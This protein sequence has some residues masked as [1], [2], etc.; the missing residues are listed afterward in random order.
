MRLKKA[1]TMAEAILVMTILGIIATIMISTLKPSQ[2]K[3]QAFQVLSKSIYAEIDSAM[4]QILTN[5]TR[6]NTLEE[7]YQ[8]DANYAPTTTIFKM[9]AGS[10][11]GEFVKILKKYMATAR[12]TVPAICR[13]TSLEGG[14]GNAYDANM[15]LKNGACLAV[16]SGSVTAKT[17]IPGELSETASKAYTHGMIFLDING[18]TDPNV[19]GKDQ[20]YIPLVKA[21]IVSGD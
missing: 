21:G 18:D 17:W 1:F 15:L 12:G 13:G 10:K 19:F 11:G 2:Y 3:E 5:H 7:I 8:V 4:T 14:G 9:S 16:K 6:Y 20:F